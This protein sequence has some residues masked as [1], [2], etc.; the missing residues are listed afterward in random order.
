MSVRGVRSWLGDRLADL[1]RRRELRRL[2]LALRAHRGADPTGSG[3]HRV[4]A[5]K[6]GRPVL[7]LADSDPAFVVVRA[8]ARR[9]AGPE[10]VLLATIE[11][12]IAT[13]RTIQSRGED[14]VGRGVGTAVL[15]F[16]EDLL[17]AAGVTRVTGRLSPG[18][19]E[20][21]NRQVHFYRKNGYSVTLDGLEGT[22]AKDLG[23][24]RGR[25]P[26]PAEPGSA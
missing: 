2:S 17:G 20:H 25:R 14:S 15:R 24:R 26:G 7:L 4:V 6:N 9:G 1:R 21:R 18:D 5:D 19:I 8:V 10:C 11:D 23:P 22:I 13:I 12:G 3:P 16:A